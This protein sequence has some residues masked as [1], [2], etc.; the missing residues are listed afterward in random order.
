M[1]SL[2]SILGLSR[3]TALYRNCIE[4]TAKR[5]DNGI[6]SEALFGIQRTQ[7]SDSEIHLSSVLPLL[8]LSESKLLYCDLLLSGDGEVLAFLRPGDD[9][10]Y[11][12]RLVPTIV[13]LRRV[14]RVG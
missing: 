1:L 5:R 9:D 13:V 6:A 2:S 8:I 14:L 7:K 10:F 11:E 12:S 4:Y 3:C